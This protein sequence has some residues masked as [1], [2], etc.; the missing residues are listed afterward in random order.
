[1]PSVLEERR[2]PFRVMLVVS[3]EQYSLLLLRFDRLEN[4]AVLPDFL[5]ENRNAVLQVPR[6]E[7][8]SLQLP[9][10]LL[11]PILNRFV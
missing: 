10:F 7:V 8:I 11:D 3:D 6:L 5:N 1:M 9:D 2:V 4:Q